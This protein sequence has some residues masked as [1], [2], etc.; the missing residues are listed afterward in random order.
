MGDWGLIYFPNDETAKQRKLS[1]LWHGPYG[2]GSCN[3]TNVPAVKEH[4]PVRMHAVKVLHTR[5]ISN[6]VLKDLRLAI[7]GM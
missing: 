2:V 5:P 7:T 3:E 4:F 6:L 1:H